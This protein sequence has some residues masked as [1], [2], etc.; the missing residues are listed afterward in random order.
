[1][2]CKAI[3]L[4]GLSYFSPVKPD[5]DPP[6][7]TINIEGI[8]VSSKLQRYSSGLSLKIIPSIELKSSKQMLL[9]DMFGS[10]SNVLVNSYGPGGIALVSLRGLGTYH[11]SILWNGINLQ[12]PMH[13]GVN[14]S[15]I[16]INFID[17]IA[18]QYGGNGALF[19]SGAIGGTI[20]IDNS[21]ELG[22][23]HS[24]EFYQT[25]GSFNSIFSG[26]NYTYSGSN[27][28]SSTRFF[29][30]ESDNNFRFHN[31]ARIG[32]PYENQENSNS[33]KIG[34]LQNFVFNLSK[35]HKITSSTWFQK[36]FN[37]FPPMMTS[38]TNNEYE[39][40]DFIRSVVQWRSS[41]SILDIN[42]KGSFFNENQQYRNPGT[43]EASDHKLN[44][45]TFE[46]EAIIKIN[47][48]HRLETGINICYEEVSSTN[49]FSHKKRTRPA[50]SLTYKFSNDDGKFELF[51]GV[52]EEMVETKTNPITWS[53]GSRLKLS[54][55]FNLRGNIS[56]NY[57]IPAMNDLYWSNGWGNPYLKPEQGYGEEIGL[58]YLHVNDRSNLLAKFSVFNNNVTDWIIWMP[59]G[60]VW[61]PS[62]T[63]K[64]W[65]RG[66]DLSLNYIMH[67][68]NWSFSTELNGT[69][70][71]STNEKSAA[72][73][74]NTIGKQLPY[75]PKIKAGITV[76]VIYKSNRIK[77][78]HSY[79]GKRYT[80]VDNTMQID[81]Y[82]Y[83][84]LSLE[85]S[86]EQKLFT[87]NT[88]LRIDN[89]LNEEY[90]VKDQYPMPLRSYQLGVSIL[91]NK[92]IR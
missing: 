58:D 6:V 81:P 51:A 87:I 61:N 20:H 60:S 23:G 1:M 55:S 17:Q 47:N 32:K 72:E 43:G 91:F 37:R 68:V 35:K 11:T 12:S 50:T 40:F 22:K 62:N 66:L 90:Q 67:F 49:Y 69:S 54:K 7:D 75:V 56:R 79:N 13:G 46:S 84:N 92:P 78:C 82:T 83:A 39:N 74:I 77:Y 73:T 24:A 19:G 53:V 48:N 57:R 27:V 28:A 45:G 38:Y 15:S 18:I 85:K 80:N 86:F 25:Y 88:F 30:S 41:Y 8:V 65:S 2:L 76:A 3:I 31:T 71:L 5:G 33:S 34:L 9:S 26:L 21:L 4:V 63:K 64:V 70:T 89:L 14:L 52:R 29:Y 44:T 10:L 59:N 42:T 16:P 36:A